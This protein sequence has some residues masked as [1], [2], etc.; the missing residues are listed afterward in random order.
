MVPMGGVDQT[1]IS[2][3]QVLWQVVNAPNGQQI[4]KFDLTKFPAG[5]GQAAAMATGGLMDPFETGDPD[6]LL[7]GYDIQVLG[8]EDG[9]RHVIEF[10][11]K[12]GEG[13]KVGKIK[14]WYG[15]SDGFLYKAEMYTASGDLMMTQEGMAPSFDTG[16]S[17]DLF[18]YTP[19]PGAHVRDGN[20]MM[21]QMRQKMEQMKGTPG[22]TK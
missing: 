3:G 1:S 6:K 15:V 17:D 20:E 16:L 7:K 8:K 22:Q 19:P 21:N 18:R 4:V 2:D 10:R 14:K 11:Q 9:K 13:G 12:V 5:K